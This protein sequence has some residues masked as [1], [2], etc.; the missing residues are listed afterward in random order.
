MLYIFFINSL[1]VLAAVTVHYEFLSRLAAKMPTFTL[2]PRL[3]IL[4]GVIGALIAHSIEVWIF[5]IAYYLM[6]TSVGWGGLEGNFDGSFWDCVYFSFSTFT[7]LGFG[8]I[9]PI[10]DLRYLTGLESLTGLVLV[11]W[12]ASFLFIEMQRYWNSKPSDD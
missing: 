4:V 9:A 1:I 7:T 2:M 10:G 6:V 3:R 12:T 8:D 11:T 5:A